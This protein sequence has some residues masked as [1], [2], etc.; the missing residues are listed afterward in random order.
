MTLD[1]EPHRS[2]A[3][4]PAGAGRNWQQHIE[5]RRPPILH[6]KALLSGCDGGEGARMPGGFELRVPPPRRAGAVL[7][8][9]SEWDC[10]RIWRG[11]KHR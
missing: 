8:G 3:I 9:D 1:R 6:L 4:A 7:D 11:G 2:I 10:A 5:L